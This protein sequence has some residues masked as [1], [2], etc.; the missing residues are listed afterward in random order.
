[1][2]GAVAAWSVA[3]V[4]TGAAYDVVLVAHILLAVAALVAVITAGVAALS[5]SRPG[6]VSDGLRRYYRPGVNWAGRTLLL[7]PVL[8]VAL[9]AMSKGQWSFSD[10]WVVVGSLLWVVAA[11]LAEVLLWPS[12]RQLQAEVARLPAADRLG[13]PSAVP[14]STGPGDVAATEQSGGVDLRPLCLRAAG[15]AGSVVL[16]VVIAGVLMVAKP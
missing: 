9:V 2:N 12:E 3:D 8:G 7:V 1:V 5:L 13:A 6:P 11:S 15:A 4:S 16:L 10:R 14:G